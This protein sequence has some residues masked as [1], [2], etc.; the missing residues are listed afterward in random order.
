MFH[1]MSNSLYIEPKVCGLRC[2]AAL[3]L[4]I[5]KFGHRACIFLRA[6]RDLW[7]HHIHSRTSCI[8]LVAGTRVNMAISHTSG[9]N[10][11]LGYVGYGKNE[12]NYQP[13]LCALYACIPITRFI[14]FF[15]SLICS[16]SVDHRLACD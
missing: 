2:A 16:V 6:F 8:V 11:D 5:S 12:P 4:K 14:S 7:L 9:T 1:Y 3:A 13:I 15:P 10:G